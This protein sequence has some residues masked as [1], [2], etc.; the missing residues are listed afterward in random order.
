MN[1]S[2]GISAQREAAHLNASKAGGARFLC[3]RQEHINIV[4]IY[5]LPQQTNY[6]VSWESDTLY[7][8]EKKMSFRMQ[9]GNVKLYRILYI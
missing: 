3:I 2:V 8:K 4:L 7:R 5:K 6:T 9:L 1:H